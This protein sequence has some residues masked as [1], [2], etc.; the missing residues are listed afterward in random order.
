MNVLVLNGPSLG[1]LGTRE[2]ALYGTTTLAELERR[3]REIGAAAGVQVSCRQHDDEEAFVESVRTA[4]ADAI[5]MNP[6]ALTHTSHPLREAVEAYGGPVFEV[7]ITNIHAREPY[8][9]RSMV[10][11][12]SRGSVIGL[13]VDG[14]ACALE[15]AIRAIKDAI[16][17]EGS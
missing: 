14:Y 2:P 16:M 13:G 17:E 7:H 15:A 9:R 4:A 3:L 11:S 6:A 10:S 8:R 12:L 5:V 1:R